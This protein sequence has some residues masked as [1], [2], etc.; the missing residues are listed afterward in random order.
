MLCANLCV[1]WGIWYLPTMLS[2]IRNVS[3]SIYDISI[4][5]RSMSESIYVS[6][7]IHVML[8]F[9][10]NMGKNRTLCVDSCCIQLVMAK[11]CIHAQNYMWHGQIHLLTFGDCYYWVIFRHYFGMWFNHH[12]VLDNLTRNASIINSLYGSVVERWPVNPSAI[13]MS[14]T[15]CIFPLLF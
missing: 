6:L 8:Q 4:S 7:K 9:I 2:F 12:K 1:A 11:S 5:L 13:G 3:L 15:R 14:P 10:H